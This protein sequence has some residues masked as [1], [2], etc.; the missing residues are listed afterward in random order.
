MRYPSGIGP[1]VGA[2]VG[3]TVVVLA[4]E[5]GAGEAFADTLGRATGATEPARGNPPPAT[6]AIPTASSSTPASRV[7]ERGT[8]ILGCTTD[9]ERTSERS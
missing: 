2:G 7:N 1:I 8:A 4:G 9:A 5:T 6:R 3:D